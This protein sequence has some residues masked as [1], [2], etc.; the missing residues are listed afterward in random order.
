[1]SH[2]TFTIPG[3]RPALANELIYRDWRVALSRKARDVKVVDRAAS[4]AGVVLVAWP[5]K[6]LNDAKRAGLDPNQL[7]DPPVPRRRRVVF[8]IHGR[9]YGHPKQRPDPD[10]PLKSFLDALKHAGLI[11]DDDDEWCLCEPPIFEVGPKKT[12]IMLEDLP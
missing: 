5:T 2:H 4:L 6:V 1:M 9:T 10:G 12:V 11:V 8:E 7:P 3:W